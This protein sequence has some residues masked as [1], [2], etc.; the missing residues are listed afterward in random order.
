MKRNSS[1][2]RYFDEE[3]HWVERCWWFCFQEDVMSGH[4][5]RRRLPWAVAT[6][7]TWYF[8]ALGDAVVAVI[9]CMTPGG[10][11]FYSNTSECI[12][13]I[14]MIS[15][16]E[17]RRQGLN[18]RVVSKWAEM[19]QRSV[20][21][22]DDI[23]AGRG[24]WQ[25]WQRFR[26]HTHEEITTWNLVT[27]TTGRQPHFYIGGQGQGDRFSSH[28]TLGT[29]WKVKASSDDELGECSN[30]FGDIWSPRLSLECLFLF[31]HSASTPR[32][33]ISVGCWFALCK[34][35]MTVTGCHDS[36]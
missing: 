25:K 14:P 1:G 6:L 9:A 29:W 34:W 32:Y 24:Y 2:T 36:S 35:A 22:V 5:N 21:K 17:D 33:S 31:R 7:L 13:Q 16:N 10:R 8:A 27:A 20:C 15:F 26:G 19:K 28:G 12:G 23:W 18:V 11:W 30:N 3:C 4:C